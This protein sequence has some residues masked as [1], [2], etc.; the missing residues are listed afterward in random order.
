MKNKKQSKKPRAKA[1]V[2]REKPFVEA[3]AA[4][5]APKPAGPPLAG[6]ELERKVAEI[7]CVRF[8]ETADRASLQEKCQGADDAA[9]EAAIVS[10][11]VRTAV[12]PVAQAY[13]LEQVIAVLQL[14]LSGA[15][16]ALEDSKPTAAQIAA[17]KIIVEVLVEKLLEKVWGGVWQEAAAALFASPFEQSVVENMLQLLRG[18][19]APADAEPLRAPKTGEDCAMAN[20]GNAG[21]PGEFGG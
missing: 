2:K 6:E 15:R 4:V 16:A 8:R 5:S 3:P 17:L 14:L 7:L 11:R 20:D 13:A 19:K 18:H 1:A 21:L 9:I 10:L 12:E